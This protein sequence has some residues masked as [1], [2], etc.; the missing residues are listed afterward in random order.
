MEFIETIYA[1]GK[2]HVRTL[3]FVDSKA[4]ETHASNEFEK[5][6]SAVSMHCNWTGEQV[7]IYFSASKKTWS[8][9]SQSSSVVYRLHLN[10]QQTINYDD[11]NDDHTR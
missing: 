1:G 8:N 11:T 10:N 6:S 9:G 2:P 5:I 4:A 7:S 3:D